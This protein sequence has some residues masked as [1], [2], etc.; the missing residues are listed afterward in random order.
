MPVVVSDDLVLRQPPD[1][2]VVLA[3]V[4]RVLD[5]D[6]AHLV[7]LAGE[8]AFLR[9]HALMQHVVVTQLLLVEKFLPYQTTSVTKFRKSWYVMLRSSF[10]SSRIAS[11]KSFRII[12]W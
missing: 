7:L 3:V 8:H 9:H 5:V 2:V 12:I 10:N 1:V 4:Q 11:K 6:R